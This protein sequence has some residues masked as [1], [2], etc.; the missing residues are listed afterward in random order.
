MGDF[1]SALSAA[2][3]IGFLAALGAGLFAAAAPHHALA[4]DLK[5]AVAIAV[6]THPSVQ[7]TIDLKRS[8]AQGVA[9]ARAGRL[10]SV[11]GRLSNGFA[12]S[13]NSSTRARAT[14]NPDGPQSD[15]MFRGESSLALTQMLFDGKGTSSRVHAAQSRLALAE[16]QVL[17]SSELIGLRAVAAFLGVARDRQ[18]LRLAEDNLSRHR[19]VVGQIRVQVESGGGS[20]A[21]LD[22][23]LGR[24]A[25]AESTAYQVAGRLR[26]SE[27]SYLEALGDAPADLT[28][29][30]PTPSAVPP[31]RDA[32]I[33]RAV[34]NNPA[35]ASARANIEA[36]QS[37][38]EATRAPFLPRVDLEL[39]GS[40]NESV[41]G[42]EGAN[43]DLTAAV[44]F[45]YNFYRGG[46]D[47]ARL[48]ATGALA[49]EAQNRFVETRRL[50]EQ[51]VRVS[52]NV[53]EVA[54]LRI[55]ALERHAASSQRALEAYY[56]QFR[57]GQ[58][59][60]LDVLNAETEAYQARASLAEG[61]ISVLIG[62]YQVL[63]ALGELLPTLRGSTP[64]KG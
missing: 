9:E 14:R 29:P 12:A 58:R 28:V 8:A 21:D 7:A 53:Y 44:V 59:T 10:P 24:L 5:E 55:P 22:Q 47:T 2:G 48:R 35:L 52:F 54:T 31:D 56:E 1:F 16:S 46:A 41:G 50:V 27:A 25:L 3:R 18:L 4:L 34:A 51:N 61:R 26:D 33:E 57:L 40:R 38:R 11:D 49:A 6:S 13:N 23:A 32:A 30:E 39:R 42:V 20:T 60:L 43:N 45:T 64:A 63:A 37:D 17:D 19:D 15:S 62:Q 36:A